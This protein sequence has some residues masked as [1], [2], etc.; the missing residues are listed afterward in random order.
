MGASA[1]VQETA[2]ALEAIGRPYQAYAD[3]VREYDVGVKDLLATEGG[4]DKIWDELDLPPRNLEKARLKRELAQLEKQASSPGEELRPP[5]TTDNLKEDEARPGEEVTAH[6]EAKYEA[7]E[8]VAHVD[9][10]PKSDLTEIERL[11]LEAAKIEA[12][13]VPT[14]QNVLEESYHVF[15]GY[16]VATEEI[17][18]TALY[19]KLIMTSVVDKI[20]MPPNNAIVKP[21]LDK[22]VLKDGEPWADGFAAGL[23][24]S[25]V[26][27]PVMSVWDDHKGSVGGLMN[28]KPSEG[29]DWVDNVLLE[30]EFALQVQK[31]RPDFL[32][33]MPILMGPPDGRGYTE[34]PF[35]LVN[36]L[37]QEVSI[38]TKKSLLHYCT[39]HGIPLS[40]G[41]LQRNIRDTVLALTTNQGKQMWKLGAVDLAN[42]QVAKD[43]MDKCIEAMSAI[44]VNDLST[45]RRHVEVTLGG[46][47]QTMMDAG[48]P[49]IEIWGAGGHSFKDIRKA[50]CKEELE[51]K[52]EQLIKAVERY[53]ID[54]IHAASGQPFLIY[55]ILEDDL[56]DVSV[57]KALLARGADKEVQSPKNKLRPLAYAA[58]H[59]PSLIDYLVNDIMAE[60]DAVNDDGRSALADVCLRGTLDI[61][62]QLIELGADDEITDTAGKSVLHYAVTGRNYDTAIW[63]MEERGADVLATDQSGE[64]IKDFAIKNYTKGFLVYL[65]DIKKL[66]GLESV[67]VRKGASCLSLSHS[68]SVYAACFSSDGKLLA[69]ASNDAT[70]RLWEIREIGLGTAGFESEEE[71]G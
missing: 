68:A 7:V 70:A 40:Q 6:N 55:A 21:Y 30:Y 42:A 39:I 31:H 49:F 16:R 44:K 34:F 65:K 54:A 29:R 28:L 36:E 41:D 64:T 14:K 12:T 4:L 17:F 13:P 57:L 51:P 22:K 67:D 26:F 20:L 69:T 10:H 11:V 2:E 66:E 56:C 35:S 38:E 62:K 9:A 48:S 63:L 18:T 52:V 71:F 25:R 37:P 47:V 53:G 5:Q 60:I 15:I 24:N 45:V 19:D 43:I 3:K 46:S 59:R 33:I 27:C 32:R 8:E 23:A 58:L 1:S 50:G 61:V